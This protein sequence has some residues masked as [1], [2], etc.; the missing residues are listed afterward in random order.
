ME[1][2]RVTRVERGEVDR[3]AVAA[4][5]H[6]IGARD[7]PPAD[8]HAAPGVQDLGPPAIRRT[9]SPAWPWPGG[10]VRRAEVLNALPLAAFRAAV[11][12]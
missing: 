9:W 8:G 2:R 6:E 4:E 5:L 10:G 3:M 1:A 12:P 11:H 7:P